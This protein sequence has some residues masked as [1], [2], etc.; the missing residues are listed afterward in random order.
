MSEIPPITAAAILL[1]NGFHTLYSTLSVGVSPST[2]IL[3]SLYTDTPGT[4]FLVTR[5]SC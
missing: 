2:D 4:R 5:A 1:L 3:F